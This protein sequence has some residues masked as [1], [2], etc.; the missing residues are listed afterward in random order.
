MGHG[1]HPDGLAPEDE[2]EVEWEGFQIDPASIS[3]AEMRYV[4]G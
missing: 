1:Q 4:S 2:R 3:T